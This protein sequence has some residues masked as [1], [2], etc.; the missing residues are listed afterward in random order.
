MSFVSLQGNV[1]HT[2]RTRFLR[3]Q[4]ALSIYGTLSGLV[5]DYSKI[6]KVRNSHIYSTLIVDQY[7]NIVDKIIYRL[8]GGN[9]VEYG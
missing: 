2:A 5:D 9:L 1:F 3:V 8:V 4:P 7:I 6:V